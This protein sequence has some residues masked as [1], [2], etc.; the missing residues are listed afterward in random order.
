[1]LTSEQEARVTQSLDRVPFAK[2]LGIQLESYDTGVATLV[3]PLREEL[4]QN[5]G[6]VHGGAIA[7]LIDTSTAI[8]ILTVLQPHER[9]TTIDLTIN[10]L[11]PLISGQ[12]R[13]NAKVLRAGRRVISVSAEVLNNDGS[14]AATALST[15]IKLE[16]S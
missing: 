12:A 13:A 2:L 15:Y 16:Q 1:M 7:S 6:V 10:Y 11:R 14:L 8:A 5:N 4:K 9:A 3:L